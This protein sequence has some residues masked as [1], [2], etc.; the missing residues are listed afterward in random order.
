MVLAGLQAVDFVTVFDETTPLALIKAIRPDVLI[1]GSDYQKSDVVGAA[2]VE[3]YGGRVYLA[4]V[5]SGYST[6]NILRKL[7]AA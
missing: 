6:S 1:K 2:F 4:P 5:R 3:S 7:G